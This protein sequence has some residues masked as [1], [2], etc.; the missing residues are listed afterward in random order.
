MCYDSADSQQKTSYKLLTI[1]CIYYL[2]ACAA[3]EKS[4]SHVIAINDEYPF[5]LF[6]F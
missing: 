2:F 4:K 1:T 5:R 3:L 6:C